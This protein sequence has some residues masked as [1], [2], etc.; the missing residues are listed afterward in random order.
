MKIKIL[1]IALCVA[2]LACACKSDKSLSLISVSILPQ[3]YFADRIT[4]GKFNTVAM[5]PPGHNAETFEITSSQMKAAAASFIY[6]KIGYVPFEQNYME[7][8]AS[9]NP[10]M[11][12]IDTSKGIKLL[13]SSEEENPD[14]HFWLSP[15][16]AK[17]IVGNMAQAL[18]AEKPEH[19]EEFKANA[20][21][22]IKD[23]DAANARLLAALKPFA[24]KSFIC[25]HPAWGYIARDCGLTQ[26]SVEEEGKEPSPN[27][28]K[29]IADTAKKENI[30][31]M[32]LEAQFPKSIAEAAAKDMGCKV[33]LIDPLQENWIKLIDDAREAFTQ[34]L[35]EM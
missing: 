5:V 14:P 7:K 2:F 26:I 19:E 13:K 10:N 8:M 34:G 24:G 31:A 29:Y 15:T 12:I 28:L 20:A 30:R 16:E 23:I 33:I 3:K 21:A 1:C 32:F 27:R 4:G 6:F 25:F 11:K 18:C 17:I 9:L 22:L 35:S